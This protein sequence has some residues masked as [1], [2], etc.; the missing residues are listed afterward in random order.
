MI[1]N[2]INTAV[3]AHIAQIQLLL[4]GDDILWIWDEKWWKKQFKNS[5]PQ[6]H[7]LNISRF[8]LKET[9][10]LTGFNTVQ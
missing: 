7:T 5:F 4:L 10:L 2:L 1:L 9:R 3:N 6:T 8:I